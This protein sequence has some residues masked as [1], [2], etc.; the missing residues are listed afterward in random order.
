MH[1]R[2]ETGIQS[3]TEGQYQWVVVAETVE[4]GDRV[5]A[6]VGWGWGDT[7]RTGKALVASR[8]LWRSKCSLLGE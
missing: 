8:R 4:D 6:R 7:C 5:G 2:L 1:Y 3:K